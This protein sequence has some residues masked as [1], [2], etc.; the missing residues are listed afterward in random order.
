MAGLGSIIVQLILGVNVSHFYI[1]I[2]SKTIPF[3]TNQVF[4][5]ELWNVLPWDYRTGWLGI[6]TNWLGVNTTALV[7]L[8]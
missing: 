2:V 5:W 4:L 7:A 3:L 6:K 1:L 8:W